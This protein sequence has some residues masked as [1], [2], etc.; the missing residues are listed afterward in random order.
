MASKKKDLPEQLSISDMIHMN[1]RSSQEFFYGDIWKNV[2]KCVFC[3][4]KDKYTIKE[5]NGLVLTTNIY[6]Y[7][8]G[9]LMIVPKEHIG[10]IKE[11]SEEQWEGVRI[12]QY[13]AKK[14]LRKIF[15]Y[16]GLWLLYREGSGYES[17]QKTVGHLHIHLIPYV[18]DLVQWNYQKIKYHP[19]LVAK[20]FRENDEAMDKLIERYKL[21]YEK[22]D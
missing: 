1:A 5:V 7:I 9:N 21:K 17:S 18:E 2:G 10:H 6:P 20:A 3:D 13:V 22:D 8:D 15:G 16:K 19:R 14:M 12:L 4:L 11:L